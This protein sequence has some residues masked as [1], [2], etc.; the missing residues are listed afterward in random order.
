[1]DNKAG[2]L[3]NTAIVRA[4]R[5]REATLRPTIR[6]AISIKEC[7]LLFKTEPCNLIFGLLHDLCCVMTVVSL[8]GCAVIVVSLGEDE[9]VVATTEGVLEDGS[10][11]EVDV[12]V[13]TGSLVS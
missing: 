3:T 8:V 6:R 4:L 7:V 12:G 5:T 13:M 9:N 1:M 10:W 11:S 2:G